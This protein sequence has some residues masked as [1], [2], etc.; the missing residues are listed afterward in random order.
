MTHTPGNW[1]IQ[2]ANDDYTRYQVEAKGWGIIMRVEDTSNESLAN[3]RLI[4]TAPELLH[5]L[6]ILVEQGYH[7]HLSTLAFAREAIAKIRG[8]VTK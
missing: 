7:P 5:V 1:R 6:E 4:I 2:S 8:E 3:A